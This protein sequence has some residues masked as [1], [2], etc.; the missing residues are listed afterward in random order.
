[1]EFR[2]ASTADIDSVV[3]LVESAYRGQPSAPGWTTEAH[4]LDGQRTDAEAVAAIVAGASGEVV[5]G[6]TAGEIV[7]CCHLDLGDPVTAYF[8]LFAV[9][10]ELQG[11]GIG[12]ALLAEAERRAVAAGAS[13]Q[14]MTVIR[15][16]ADV[17]AWYERLGYVRTG[18]TEPFPYGDERFGRPK[19]D[20]LEFVELVKDLAPAPARAT[21]EPVSHEHA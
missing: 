7:A 11:R 2:A 5:L 18:V 6:E 19:V 15:Q 16:R 21:R 4:L 13:R 3:A 9:R 12:R 8:G 17:I 10:P 1:M 14:R 20:D